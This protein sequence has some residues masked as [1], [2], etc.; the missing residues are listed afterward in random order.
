M[1]YRSNIYIK[2]AIK[3][4]EDLVKT[5]IKADLTA[6]NFAEFDEDDNYAYLTLYDLKWYDSYSDVVKLMNNFINSL[7]N[8]GGLIA[9][10]E[11]NAVVEYGNPYAV[12]L[13]VQTEI[14]GMDSQSNT[15][16]TSK[17]KLELTISNLQQTDPKLFI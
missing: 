9:I 2:V 1:G 10:G 4:K 17:E 16:L 12:D 8:N 3:H 13:Y 5:M 7:G 11:D 14:G 6:D 15:P